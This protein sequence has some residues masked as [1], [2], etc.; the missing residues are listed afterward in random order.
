M[1]A[2]EALEIAYNE[3]KESLDQSNNSLSDEDEC[4]RT[5]APST[6][7][8]DINEAIIDIHDLF[9]HF[10]PNRSKRRSTRRKVTE[11]SMRESD[12]ELQS[13]FGEGSIKEKRK[14][15]KDRAFKE[16]KKKRGS[17]TDKQGEQ[18]SCSTQES[19]EVP[20]VKQRPRPIVDQKHFKKI[21]EVQ[22]IFEMNCLL[23]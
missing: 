2:L 17:V 20:A 15:I 14:S 6:L 3:M 13:V 10:K 12:E 16:I 19:T 7:V 18:P 4:E 1:S 8:K 9:T 11:R 5:L 21:T 22:Q 23:K